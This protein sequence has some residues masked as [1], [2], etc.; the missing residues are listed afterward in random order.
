MKAPAAAAA[1][2]TLLCSAPALAGEDLTVRVPAPGS[3]YMPRSE[4]RDFAYNYE[5]SNGKE[6]RF[7]QRRKQFFAELD[8]EPRAELFPLAPG[9]LVTAAGARVEFSADGQELTIRHYERLPMKLALKGRNITLV[10]RR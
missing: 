10:A 5:L 6:I 3:Y 4:F 7:T 8:G 9:V 2:L 1:L